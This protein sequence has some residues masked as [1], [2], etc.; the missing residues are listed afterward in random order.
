M[1]FVAEAALIALREGLEALLIIG[2]LLGLVRK[3]GR[4]DAT[5]HV[6]TGFVAGCA[7]ALVLGVLAQTALLGFYATGGA[8]IFEL[9]AAF[10]AVVI[11]TYMVFWMW[12]HTRELMSTMRAKVEAALTAGALATIAMLAFWSVLREGVEVVLFY[13]VLWSRYPASDLLLSGAVGFL[14]SAAI[15]ASILS[16]TRKVNLRAFFGITGGLL[17]LVAGGLLVHSLAALTVLGVIPAAPAIWD[18]SGLVADESAIGH[19]LHALTGYTEAPTLLQMVVYS[20]YVLGFGGAYLWG[21]GLFHTPSTSGR[22]VSKPRI[23]AFL[24]AVSV[25]VAAVSAGAANP[26]DRLAEHSPSEEEKEGAIGNHSHA[27]AVDQ[28]HALSALAA[29]PMPPSP[30]MHP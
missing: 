10:V 6:W 29:A 4:S 27:P 26:T 5:R 24:V 17:V 19:V 9:L 22:V 20:G 21:L 23:A 1:E 12:D 7:A 18:T 15:V 16:R 13:S 8:E 11:L 28:S 14:A 3:M 30:G 2:I 25:V